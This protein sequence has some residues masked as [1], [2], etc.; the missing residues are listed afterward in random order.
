MTNWT[1]LATFY[2][3]CGKK[4]PKINS[5][6]VTCVAGSPEAG[7]LPGYPVKINMVKS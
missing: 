1:K 4:D 7:G 3:K 2:L 5:E 6:V